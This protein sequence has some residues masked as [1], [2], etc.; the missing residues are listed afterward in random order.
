MSES[1]ADGDEALISV[2]VH[3]LCLQL[4]SNDP[5][6]FCHISS[7]LYFIHVYSEASIHRSDY[8]EAESIAVFQALKE[9]TSVKKIEF[10]LFER[11]CTNTAEPPSDTLSTV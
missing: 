7:R 4:R 5:L 6:I 2:A 9:N 8:T 3:K 1:D 11:H 10:M